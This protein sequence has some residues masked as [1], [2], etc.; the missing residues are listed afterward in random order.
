MANAW[1][2]YID[3]YVDA[4]RTKTTIRE[5]RLKMMLENGRCDSTDLRI[6]LLDDIEVDGVDEIVRCSSSDAVG[7]ERSVR[8]LVYQ[9]DELFWI[10]DPIGIRGCTQGE[11][12]TNLI[13]H[14]CDWVRTM[15]YLEDQNGWD[16]LGSFDGKKQDAPEDAKVIEIR[17]AVPTDGD[18]IGIMHDIYGKECDLDGESPR[19]ILIPMMEELSDEFM[20]HGVFEN[21]YTDLQIDK[22][23]S[24]DP[25]S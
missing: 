1:T 25:L 17:S 4:A 18:Y 11:D 2:R 3:D 9:D 22:L 5:E 12:Y 20:L 24:V 16:L 10:A 8:F 19:I 13:I 14:A 23:V 6:E 21:G 15:L 7:D